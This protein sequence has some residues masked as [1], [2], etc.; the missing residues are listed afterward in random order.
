M[1]RALSSPL[2]CHGLGHGHRWYVGQRLQ[3]NDSLYCERV[4]DCDF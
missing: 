3:T 2:L 4:I 1:E